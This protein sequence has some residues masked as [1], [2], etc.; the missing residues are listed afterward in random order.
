[1]EQRAWS[2]EHGAESMEQ[3]VWSRG[4][5]EKGMEQRAESRE[6]VT[7]PQRDFQQNPIT[8]RIMKRKINPSQDGAI[9]LAQNQKHETRNP[10][11]SLKKA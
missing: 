1:M 4:Y 11:R 9:E 10:N 2:R 3:R 7:C 6:R 8:Q 5:G